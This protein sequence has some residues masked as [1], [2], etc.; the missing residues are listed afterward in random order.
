MAELQNEATQLL[1]RIPFGYVI[2]TPLEAAIRA[3]TKA[4]EASFQFIQQM[5]FKNSKGDASDEIRNVVF[6]FNRYDAKGAPVKTTLTVPLLTLVP[7]PF[8][9]IDDMNISFKTKINAETKVETE[10][11][12]DVGQ[13]GSAGGDLFG[14]Y[15]WLGFSLNATGSVSSKM[16]SRATRESKYSVE[17]NIDID[18]HAVQD[19]MPSG[20]SAI[21]NILTESIRTPIQTGK[22]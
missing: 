7:I 9:R 21:L 13:S 8:L 19:D 20:V 1:N 3:Q 11:K 18:I 12:S 5:A 22:S 2:A 17:Y 16:D 6:K 15:K 4:A 14:E 10:D